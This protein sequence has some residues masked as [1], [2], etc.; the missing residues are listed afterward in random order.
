MTLA[1]ADSASHDSFYRELTRRNQGVVGDDA[2]TKLRDLRIGIFGCGS[3]GGAP[4]EI[5]T[6]LGAES[7]SLAEPGAY[8][9]D[10]LNRQASTLD[11][12][13]R[14]KA[15]VLRERIRSINPHARVLVEPRG[16]TAENVHYLVGSSDVIIDGV[17]VTEPAGIEAKILL[18]REAWRQRRVGRRV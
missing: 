16:V 6:R 13:G 3:I 12:V 9:L 10:N 14:N 11:D 1:P 17:D 8:E 15:E 2:Q 7:F 4:V 5:L 18:H